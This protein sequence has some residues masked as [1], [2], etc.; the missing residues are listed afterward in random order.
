M[1]KIRNPWGGERYRGNWSDESDLWTPRLRRQVNA[2]GFGPVEENKDGLFFM[3]LDSFM[4]N[5]VNLT[6]NKNTQGWSHA[7][8]MKL[9]DKTQAEND[10]KIYH[11]LTI[12]ND[13]NSP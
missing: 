12:T 6:I 11:E 8:F 13:H 10:G 5:F 3:D 1:L 9:D 2:M 4:E 7:Y